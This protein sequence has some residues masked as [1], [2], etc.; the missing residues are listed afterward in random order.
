M[1]R[2]TLISLLISIAT[3]TFAAISV[4]DDDGNT[5]SMSSP[6]QR[7]ISLAP[8]ATELLFVIDAGDKLVGTVEHSDH[9]AAAQRIRRVGGYN[10]LDLEIIL[11]LQ[12]DLII[13]WRTGNNPVQLEKLQALDLPV[14][15]SEPR[16]LQD[17]PNTAKRL[18]TLTGTSSQAKVF[19]QQF[20]QRYASLQQRYAKRRP[21]KLFYEIWHQPLI[22][23]NGEHLISDLIRLCGA[24]NVFA[25]VPVLAPTVSIEA[26]IS[27]APDIIVTGGHHTER[28]EWR[29]SWQRW[30]QL[31]AVI[32]DQ[33]YF[34]NPDLIQRHGPRI[35]QGAEQL[36]HDVEQARQI[37]YA[38]DK[39]L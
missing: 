18:A 38:S 29:A 4:V 20:E 39:S 12:P 32:H 16:Q 11:A 14:F 30:P 7:I 28:N 31:P 3:V 13:G 2:I 10:A 26:V 15:I 19:I 6:A 21:V 35:L 37:K 8:H 25:D 17:I 23:I 33:L 27:A 22:T 36:C 24:V 5:I 1:I 9:P 34:I